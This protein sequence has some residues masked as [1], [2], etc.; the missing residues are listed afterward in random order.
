MDPFGATATSRTRAWSPVPFAMN[1]SVNEL[2]NRRTS[3]T[4]TL[5]TSTRKMR[6]PA[7]S[8]SAYVVVGSRPTLI[9]SVL[10]EVRCTAST[11]RLLCEAIERPRG[12]GEGVQGFVG[13][14][15]RPDRGELRRP[16]PPEACRA[17][18]SARSGE[19][20]HAAVHVGCSPSEMRTRRH[21]GS[22]LL[23]S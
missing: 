13:R 23:P 18:G 8:Q 7:S 9:S 6:A 5:V 14:L 20:M 2:S 15:A 16:C 22:T 4:S 1:S 19:S 11:R 3:D 21:R 17:V 10:H 12:I